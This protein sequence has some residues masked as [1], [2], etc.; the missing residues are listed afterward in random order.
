MGNPMENMPSLPSQMATSGTP[1]TPSS[2]AV[3]SS[4]PA[5]APTTAPA[6]LDSI[7]SKNKKVLKSFDFHPLL[8]FHSHFDYPLPL[9]T[10]CQPLLSMD[11]NTLDP[12]ATRLKKM[13]NDFGADS[14]G[15][16]GPGFP[17]SPLSA[18]EM[19]TFNGTPTQPSYAW[20][21]AWLETM[22]VSIAVFSI[23]D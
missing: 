12:I 21:R 9:L 11:K 18:A 5:P 8:E 17:S 2:W 1:P 10:E 4:A 15:N 14:S 23:S 16:E 19:E 3:S 7:L 6:S 20:G 22:G 13:S